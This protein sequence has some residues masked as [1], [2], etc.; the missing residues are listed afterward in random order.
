MVN[1]QNEGTFSKAISSMR[2]AVKLDPG[3]ALG[4]A[5]LAE[6]CVAGYFNRFDCGCADPLNDAVV[7]GNTAL[8]LDKNCHHAYQAL[9]L[10]YIFRHEKQNCLST[11]RE[12]ISMNS[13][14]AG[15]A[16]GI[17]FCMVCCGEYEKGYQ[18]LTDSIYLNP[19]YQWWFNAGISMYHL[20][21]DEYDEAI[22]WAAK[23]QQHNRVWGLLLTIT[24]LVHAGRLPDAEANAKTLAT[25]LPP[26]MLDNVV[27]AFILDD[28]L[29]DKI[30]SANLR[31][32]PFAISRH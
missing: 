15:I 3:Y 8:K 30:M 27:H 7:Y 31:S 32:L 12:W 1:E 28:T 22:Y 20:V 24:A 18:M 14:V 26:D 6:T 4:W 2:E 9:A 13:N 19:F 16:G 25:I 10:A 5:I 29:T 21:K 11:A 23:L 17:G